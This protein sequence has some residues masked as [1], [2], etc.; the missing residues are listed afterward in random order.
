MPRITS[1]KEPP[2]SAR[3][4]FIQQGGWCAGCDTRPQSSASGSIDSRPSLHNTSYISITWGYRGAPP[5][6]LGSQT[7]SNNG[8][9]QGPQ[10][11][12]LMSLERALLLEPKDQVSFLTLPPSSCAF[13]K[14][15]VTLSFKVN[16]QGQYPVRGKQTCLA[17]CTDFAVRTKW[18]G[19]DLW[20]HAES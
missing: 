15:W 6:H 10:T 1:A 13:L 12:T 19:R 20:M 7:P 4:P 8:I 14:E 16:I 3:R 5:V 17:V 11:E 18:P 9:F 2:I